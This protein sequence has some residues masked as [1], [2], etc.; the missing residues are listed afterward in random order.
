MANDSKRMRGFNET[1]P[2]VEFDVWF[3]TKGTLVTG[4]RGPDH[5]IAGERGRVLGVTLRNG[6]GRSSRE[7][8]VMA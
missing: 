1:E 5:P 8:P 6:I 2:A 4:G 7:P 3:V